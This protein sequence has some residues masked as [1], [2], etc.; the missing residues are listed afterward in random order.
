LVSKIK[1]WGQALGFSQIGVAG[2]DLSAAEP[3]LSAWLAKGF[4]GDMAYMAA[5]G[6][7]RARPAEL[8][9]G[10]VRVITARM[11]YLPTA[12]PAD[13]QAVEWQRLHQPT[14]AIV[15]VYARGRDYHK[16]MRS[17]LQRLCDQITAELGP[18][19]YR[20]FTDSAPVLEAELARA[21]G[22]GW[23]GKHTLVLNREAGSM[24]FLGE[25]FVD[26]ALP[27]DAPTTSH[28]G[29][30]TACLTVCP[31]QA[32][33]APYQLDARRCISYLTIEHAGPIPLALRPLMANR[34][35]GCDDCQLV[36]P[37]NK[38][39][40]RSALP[41]FDAR[42]GLVGAQLVTLFAWTE[43]Q[44]LRYTE[45]SPIRR[46]GHER[47]L[48]NLAVALGN[49]LRQCN[50]AAPSAPNACAHE[51]LALRAALLSRADH[52]SALVQEHVAWALAQAPQ[53]ETR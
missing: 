5:H 41:D 31:T 22:Q 13:W 2:V 15:S 19:G 43:A 49:A 29:H 42:T 30:C 47:W 14:Q 17:R 11:D 7:K 25:I 38:F 45:G 26:L 28:C 6:T 27:I 18:L 35:Y 34:I 50:P 39:A 4:H 53:S 8:V 3:G 23:R 40:Q 1:A 10:T 12:T 36:C 9:P 51:Q 46:I 32:I 16:V 21:S 48:R 24:F 44:F 52:P 20:V 33:V 37:W